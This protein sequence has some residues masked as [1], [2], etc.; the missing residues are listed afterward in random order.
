MSVFSTK[1][2]GQKVAVNAANVS[3]VIQSTN[4]K[5]ANIVYVD[6]SYH[7]TDV[8]Y[9]STRKNLKKAL[10]SADDSFE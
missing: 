7:E 6:G 5:T 2:N 9:D 10:G 8:G 4:G 1:V 3:Y